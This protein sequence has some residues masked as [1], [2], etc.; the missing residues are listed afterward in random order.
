MADWRPAQA[1]NRKIKKDGSGDVPSLTFVEN[2]DILLRLASSPRAQSGALLCVGFAAESHDLLAHAIAKRSRKGVPVLVG[3]IGPDTFGQ[4]EN[5]L[6]VVDAH[7]ATE[8]PRNTK[9]ALARLLIKN[10]AGR[11]ATHTA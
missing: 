6:L 5:A 2:S 10:L 3:N 4:D 9:I 7:G 11:L 1:A 8:I